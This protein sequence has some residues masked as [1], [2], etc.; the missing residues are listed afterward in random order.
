MNDLKKWY[1]YTLFAVFFAS[2]TYILLDYAFRHYWDIDVWLAMLYW[3]IWSIIFS[4]PFILL[5]KSNRWKVKSTIINHWKILLFIWITNS[6]F[7]IMWATAIKIW[8]SWPV[9]LLSKCDIIFTFLLWIF[10][11]NEKVNYKE[12]IWLSIAIIWFWF[13]AFLKWEI[14]LFAAFLIVVWKAIFSIQSFIAKKYAKWLYWFSFAYV[15]M[16]ITWFF[17]F[18]IIIS[19]WSLAWIPIPALFLF[20]LWQLSWTLVSRIFYFESHNFLDISK[21]NTMLL[22]TPV[23]VL[24]LAYF[25]FWDPI[26]M[27]KWIWAFL[28]VSGLT[29]FISNRYFSER[30]EKYREIGQ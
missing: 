20:V 19:K 10:L 22:L 27:Q 15:R 7:T 14:S 2:I 3:I 28:I 12:L 23:I 16:L 25:I 9:W 17:L 18:L 6:I 24:F 29:L 8:W 26:S 11:L 21:L 4:S 5:S 13:I 1:I 30:I